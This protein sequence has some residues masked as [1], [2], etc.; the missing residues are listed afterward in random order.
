M[1]SKELK[2]RLKEEV[3]KKLKEAAEIGG[4]KP[5]FI[6]VEFEDDFFV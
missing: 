1:E 5:E 4:G 2:K 3:T 6:L